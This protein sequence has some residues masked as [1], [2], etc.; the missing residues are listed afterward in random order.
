MK[1]FKGI[2][3]MSSILL[4]A[5]LMN[6][7]PVY[8]A[9]MSHNK[10]MP[11]YK[12]NTKKS[13]DKTTVEATNHQIW[14]PITAYAG[15]NRQLLMEEIQSKEGDIYLALYGRTYEEQKQVKGLYE[16]LLKW[17]QADEKGQMLHSRLHFVY[18]P[19]D[20]QDTLFKSMP[21]IH[22]LNVEVDRQEDQAFIQYLND[23]YGKDYALILTDRLATSYG[24]DVS[25]GL[26]AIAKVY[27]DLSFEY[28]EVDEIF[29]QGDMRLLPNKYIH[30]YKGLEEMLQVNYEP[31][32]IDQK[33]INKG[34][35][36]TAPLQFIVRTEEPVEYIEYKVND[37]PAGQSFRYP[38]LITI[39]PEL[40]HQGINEV[41]VIM[42]V[43]GQ[44]DYQVQDFYMDYKGEVSYPAR[45]ARKAETYPISKQPIYR[46][47]HSRQGSSHT[48]ST[49]KVKP[50]E[51]NQV[52]QV[53]IPTLM[54]HKFKDQVEPTKE[55][56]SMSVST[57]LFEAQL[58]A[59]LEAGY[60]PINFKQLED[61]LEGKAGLPN[62]PILITADDGYLC[63]YT[64]AYPILK[65]YG[66]QATFF[67]TSLYA[68]VTN[69][70]EHFT[71]EQAKEMEASGLIDIQSHTHGHTLMDE[72]NRND[73][74]YEVQK[75]F[76][77][78]E[79]YLGKR[80]IKVL[81]YPRFLHTTQVKEWVKGCGVDLQVTNLISR[82]RPKATQ[83]VD[84]KRI[85]VSNEMSPEQLVKAIKKVTQ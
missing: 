41:K 2:H 53:Y 20:Q 81:A 19:L 57:S 49:E 76:A 13:M 3:R 30:F 7:T 35:S 9:E 29:R 68:G 83:A 40:L 33:G 14:K 8:A 75:S 36:T 50:E 26:D 59:L 67:V 39:A 11:I 62:K 63:N 71:W 72:L 69:E 85:H 17:M 43:E 27:Y 77:D 10:A 12:V 84:I 5:L 24:Q 15:E 46:D 45:A 66:A 55:D 44:K 1:R 42:K 52:K 70:H 6:T 16:D 47:I 60:T 31:I 82:F 37:A 58:K 73:V 79:K 54:Y 34:I 38:Y 32:S 4:V 51:V 28:E 80:D 21:Y 23:Q 22:T 25:K 74:C 18:T 56:Q 61:Y 78:I 65:K 48:K 64:K